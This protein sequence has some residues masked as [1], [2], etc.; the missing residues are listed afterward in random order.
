MHSPRSPVDDYFFLRHVNFTSPSNENFFVFSKPLL[1]IL[2]PSCAPEKVDVHQN[3]VNKI[4]ITEMNKGIVWGQR[5]RGQ[6]DKR[7]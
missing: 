6:P 3:G 4:Y 1:L 5:N 7:R 2:C